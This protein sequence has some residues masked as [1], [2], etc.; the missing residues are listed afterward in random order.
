LSG[1]VETAMDAVVTLDAEQRV[2]A[3]NAA[4]RMFGCSA[5]GAAGRSAS[6]S[7]ST[8]ASHREQVRRFGETGVTAGAR[9][10]LE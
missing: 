6:P 9:R 2:V 5:A 10:P 8:R 7:G 1:V 4:E 3:F